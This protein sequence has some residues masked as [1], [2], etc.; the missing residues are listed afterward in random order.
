MCRFNFFGLFA[1][2]ERFFHFAYTRVRNG[3]L[4]LPLE[5]TFSDAES[6]DACYTICMDTI[7]AC[8]LFR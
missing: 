4:D 8:N 5:I 3:Q 6:L 1:A 7:K 2:S